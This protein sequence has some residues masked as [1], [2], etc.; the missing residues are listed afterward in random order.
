MC[1]AP[2]RAILRAMKRALKILLLTVVGLLVGVYVAGAL[3][4]TETLAEA[5][6]AEGRMI[7]T[8]M[9]GIFVLEAGPQEGPPLLFAHGT[10]AWSGLWQPVLEAAGR[11]G[12]R[13][14]AFDMPP[15]GFSERDAA[16]G[17]AR[18]TQAARVQA[19][20]EVM[21]IRPVIVAHSF[22]A[23]A[24]VEAAMRAPRDYAG[25]IVVDGALGLGSHEIPRDVP[26][27]LRP[28]PLRR[29]ALRL[30][31]TNPLA[32]RPI[33]RS[34]IHVDEAATRARVNLLNR[35][36]RREGTTAAY[37]EWL[38]SLLVPPQEALSTRAESYAALRLPVTY[39]WGA[40]DDVTPLAQ[41]E[42]LAA[43]TPGANLIVIPDVGHIPQIEDE[44]A[45]L[46]VLLPAIR[47]MT[48][49]TAN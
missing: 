41:A 24:M 20:V 47:V 33:L 7:A 26:L 6:P 25:L 17:Y 11:A 34:L 32:M 49:P 30:T 44:A 37:A 16:G 12:Y 22:G 15:F 27:L 4:E 39:I 2:G 21:E 5:M 31:V 42:A 1:R 28:G 43:L 14:I 9:G 45:F 3:R 46:D 48:P 13:A 36:M 8:E 29:L 38:P 19:L 10:A 40:E 18:S 23:G 35:P